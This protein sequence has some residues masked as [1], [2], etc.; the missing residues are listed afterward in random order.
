MQAHAGLYEDI[1][2]DAYEAKLALCQNKIDNVKKSG[3]EGFEMLELV[4]QTLKGKEC[5]A[6]EEHLVSHMQNN[7]NKDNINEAEAK[8]IMNKWANDTFNL[9][10][11]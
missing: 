1:Y 7:L 9:M 2:N 5:K 3:L 8:K 11:R 10:M 6:M 4:Q